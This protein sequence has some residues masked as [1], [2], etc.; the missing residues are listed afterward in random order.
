MQNL[1]NSQNAVYFSILSFLVPN[2]SLTLFGFDIVKQNFMHI[3]LFYCHF[4]VT[5][6][7]Q[8]FVRAQNKIVTKNTLK[9]VAFVKANLY[10][11][12]QKEE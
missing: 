8:I 5:D 2:N 11:R 9:P 7:S 10:R 4:Y 6:A 3:F 1:Y 12:F